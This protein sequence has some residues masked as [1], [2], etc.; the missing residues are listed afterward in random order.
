MRKREKKKKM[1]Q[2]VR[3]VDRK[4]R[5]TGNGKKAVFERWRMREKTLACVQKKK[6]TVGEQEKRGKR[7]TC[8]LCGWK[9]SFSSCL[10]WNPI[11]LFSTASA[12][13]MQLL[14]FEEVLWVTLMKAHTYTHHCFAVLFVQGAWEREKENKRRKKWCEKEAG[15][16]VATLSTWRKHN[17]MTSWSTL[18][19]NSISLFPTFFWHFIVE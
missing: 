1:P 8:D 16:F 12:S 5:T 13:N 4:G 2:K 19:A 10:L 18:L 17:C 3:R 9:Y 11:N 14:I 15:S 7:E 6:V